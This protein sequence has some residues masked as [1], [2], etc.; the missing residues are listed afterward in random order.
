MFEG[1]FYTSEVRKYVWNFSILKFQCGS[2][3]IPQLI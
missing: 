2:V 1:M 3:R